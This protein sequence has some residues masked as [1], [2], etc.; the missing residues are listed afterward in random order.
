MSTDEKNWTYEAWLE[1][2]LE[3]GQYIA[4]IGKG[5]RVVSVWLITAARRVR[6]KTVRETQGWALQVIPAPDMRPNA[7]Y[8]PETNEL[9][10]RGEKG[11]PLFWYPR[12]PKK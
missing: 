1:D 5:D 3:P 6:H 8:D 7:V 10:V 9:W 12:S 11:H 2:V 4:S